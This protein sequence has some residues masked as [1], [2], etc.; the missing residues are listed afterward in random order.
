MGTVSRRL[1]TTVLSSVFASALMAGCSRPA[2]P[3]KIGAADIGGVVSGQH[4]AEAGVW[5]V[6]ETRDLP[7]R[8]ARI[9]VTD[10]KGR[11]VVPD[12]PRAA[13]R[14]WARGY[15]ILDTPAVQARPGATVA[16]AAHDA[17]S[18]QA[19][20]GYPAVYWYSM[21]RMPR[22]DELTGPTRNPDA[23]DGVTLAQWINTMKAGLCVSCH[24][25]GDLATRT[26]PAAFKGAGSSQDQWMR[27]LQSGSAGATMV[28]GVSALGPLAIKTLADW[29]D[30]IAAGAL[31][32]TKPKRPE[33]LERNVVF[34]TWDWLDAKHY[35]HD[36]IS[37]DP[38]NPTVNAYGPVYGST[39]LSTNDFPVLDPVRNTV[40]VVTASVRDSDTPVAAPPPLAASAYWGDEPIWQS[41]ANIHNQMLDQQGRLWAAAT[42]RN[43]ANEPAFCKAGSAH[44]S[45]QAEPLARALRQLSMYDPKTG[46]YSY[47]DTC[48]AT[49]H[50]QFDRQDRLWTSG[51][52][53]V[54]GWLDV[55]LYDRTHDAAKAQGW[56][57]LILDTNGNG[58]RDAY[59]EPGQPADPAKDQRIIAPFYAVMPSPADG[60]V[61][62]SVWI[63]GQIPAYD[64]VRIAPGSDPSRTALAEGYKL[65][66]PGYGMR[67]AAIDSQGVVWAGLASGHLAS[68]DRRKCQGRLNGPAMVSGGQCPEGWTLYRLPGP[69]FESGPDIS[70]ESSY[71]AWVDQHDTLGLGKDVPF[72]TGSLSDGFHALVGG[73]LIT[74]RLPYPL[75][76][77]AKGLDGRIDD[78]KA[79]WKGRG[80]WST[81][82]ERTPWHHEGGKGAM[83][84]AVHIQ[85]RPNPLA[86]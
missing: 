47:I 18:A 82:G 8:F 6:A 15:G 46:R 30:R 75:G 62:G 41:K 71:Y 81:S 36:A 20:Q 22:A 59:T 19:A 40:G 76:F 68:F 12:L 25:L 32:K 67:G 52:G 80:L 73:K 69:A 43:P 49:H 78:P 48:F 1:L 77:Y 27:R 24:Q 45:A 51:G 58:R 57:P 44:P 55:P 64:L 63:G 42:V 50:L 13:Y 37:T 26:I 72:V 85:L 70:A 28:S 14:V 7:T 17:T 35:L 3:P 54:V 4:G 11:F 65:P 10:D 9:V 21:L 83:P 5:V 39:E 61:W 66:A 74:L 60:S 31:P 86:D 38:R 53:P 33:G 29:T 16:L 84:F 2:A 56:T 34:T 79:G 23:A